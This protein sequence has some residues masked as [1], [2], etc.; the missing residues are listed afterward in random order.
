MPVAHQD[1]LFYDRSSAVP[2]LAPDP[3]VSDNHLMTGHFTTQSSGRRPSAL[4][5][6]IWFPSEDWLPPK[7]A[8]EKEHLETW[9]MLCVRYDF[10]VITD[11]LCSKTFPNKKKLWVK[12]LKTSVKSAVDSMT[13]HLISIDVY[14]FFI[15]HRV[16]IQW[17]YN[18]SRQHFIHI[19]IVNPLP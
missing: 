1:L 12:W 3:S 11:Y 15:V 19:Y 18:R 16:Y 10:V 8:C 2:R 4:T 17:L 6:Q 7:V 13:M 14:L 5:N 9:I